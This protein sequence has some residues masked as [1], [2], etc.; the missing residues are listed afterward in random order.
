MTDTTTPLPPVVDR[1]TW[2]AG[3]VH[4]LGVGKCDCPKPQPQREVVADLDHTGE[5][6]GGALYVPV[7]ATVR[8]C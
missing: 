4:D 1:D 8:L 2:T 5:H 7:A 3:H 6:E